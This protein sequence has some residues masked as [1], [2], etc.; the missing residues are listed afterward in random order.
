MFLLAMKLIALIFASSS[1][2]QSTS[3]FTPKVT[4]VPR[5][6]QLHMGLLGRFRQ[7]KSVELLI[8]PI[9]TGST[10]PEVDV[11]VLTTNESGE[12]VTKP[13]TIQEVLGDGT[14]ILL[15]MPGG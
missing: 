5:C 13:V 6:S 8:P 1:L 2:L 11:E 10:L 14:S 9:T 15:G 4:F 12:I 3:A 7:K